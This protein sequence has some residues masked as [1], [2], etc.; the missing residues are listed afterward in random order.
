[1]SKDMRIY[2]SG[3]ITGV[4]NYLDIFNKA[5]AALTRNGYRVVNPANLCFVLDGTATQEDFLNIDMELLRLCDVLVQLPGWEKSL[6]CQR[7][8]GAALER[9]MIIL[10]WE[11]MVDGCT[12][13]SRA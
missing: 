9:D 4:R 5:A 3:P 11:A 7:E 12:E 13:K 8:Y 1:M 2:L 6:G 10:K